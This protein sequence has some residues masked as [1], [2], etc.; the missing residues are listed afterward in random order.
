MTSQIVIDLWMLQYMLNGFLEVGCDQACRRDIHLWLDPN[1][2]S[3]LDA[4]RD[5]EARGFISILT[6]PG[7]C[8][9]KDVCFKIL[10]PIEAI[11]EPEDWKIE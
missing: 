1:S 8:K 4:L 11:P 7:S 6:E 5:W 9:E 10:R 2:D 3:V